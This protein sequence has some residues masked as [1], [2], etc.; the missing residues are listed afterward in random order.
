MSKTWINGTGQWSVITML[1]KEEYQILSWNM[2]NVPDI[3]KKYLANVHCPAWI[4]ATETLEKIIYLH[5]LI[6]KMFKWVL[7]GML[8]IYL[9]MFPATDWPLALAL[10]KINCLSNVLEIG[11]WLWPYK[12]LKKTNKPKDQ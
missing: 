2:K 10:L 3:L 8:P 5:F 7:L 12:G 9:G 1:M 4:S 6:T 11:D